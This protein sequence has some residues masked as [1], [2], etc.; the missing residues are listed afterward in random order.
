LDHVLLFQRGDDSKG[1][2]YHIVLSEYDLC[3][4]LK[5]YGKDFIGYDTKHDFMSVRFSTALVSFS[6]GENR[7][8]TGAIGISNTEN[9]ESHCLN[10]QILFAN[11][12][13]SNADCSHPQDLYIFNDLNG[14][15]FIRPCAVNEPICPTVQHDKSISIKSALISM[16]L[17]SALCNFHSLNAFRKYIVESPT[18]K[19]F[20]RPLETCFK[21]V[22]R[23]WNLEIRTKM[24]YFFE[25]F[26][27]FTIPDELLPRSVKHAFLEY[28]QKNWFNCDWSSDFTSEI[29][30]NTDVQER[31]NPLILTD[32]LTERKFRD[33]DDNI[34]NGHLNKSMAQFALVLVDKL[35]AS[36]SKIC[37]NSHGQA[38]NFER[39]GRIR[40]VEDEM[41]RIERGFSLINNK[42]VQ[43]SDLNSS[44]REGWVRISKNKTNDMNKNDQGL[45]DNFYTETYDVEKVDFF[46]EVLEHYGNTST[47]KKSSKE[48]SDLVTADHPYDAVGNCKNII[49]GLEL[50]AARILS[51]AVLDCF[52]IPELVRENYNPDLYYI[53]NTALGICT[54]YSFIIRG[55]PYLC[56]HLYAV[57]SLQENVFEENAMIEKAKRYVPTF[58]SGVPLSQFKPQLNSIERLKSFSHLATDDELENAKKGSLLKLLHDS[59]IPLNLIPGRTANRLPHYGGF[60]RNNPNTKTEISITEH[61]EELFTDPYCPLVKFPENAK[62]RHGGR[63]RNRPTSRGI[64]FSHV[65]YSA[66]KEL[67]IKIKKKGQSFPSISFS[68]E[69]SGD[70]FV[71]TESTSCPENLTKILDE[72]LEKN[73]S[74]LISN[75]K[76]KVNLNKKKSR[77]I[78]ASNIMCSICIERKSKTI[79]TSSSSLELSNHVKKV[80]TKNIMTCGDCFQKSG[81]SV[82]F[83][84]DRKMKEHFNMFHSVTP[85][86]VT[87]TDQIPSN[88]I[89][90]NNFNICK[91]DALTDINVINCAD[92][93]ELQSFIKPPGKS[94]KRNLAASKLQGIRKQR[95]KKPPAPRFDMLL[96]ENSDSK[97]IYYC[98]ICKKV[99]EYVPP[100]VACD[101]C[102]NWY[103]WRCV[104]LKKNPGKKVWY[105]PPCLDLVDLPVVH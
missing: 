11:I 45:P 5:I 70:E 34:N 95:K 92:D 96:P 15:F 93:K 6:D 58:C 88:N 74:A 101:A 20:L 13:C 25:N 57:L 97:K 46:E 48:L 100:T 83:N 43:L 2:S 60:R 51:D 65:L 39:I 85:D 9:K 47:Q 99:C 62:G 91:D 66:L 36:E 73:M 3:K 32:N 49:K 40:S 102:D 16:G 37:K 64:N 1:R 87:A 18:L 105:C 22:M 14:Y 21:C 78:T 41:K 103:H 17:K 38:E 67:C 50:S 61:P 56:K 63:K 4:V 26:V 76:Q 12:P 104:G 53:C 81:I 35:F 80:H 75:K 84:C 90:Q 77:P 98:P 68:P 31:R 72:K 94:G 19:V 71:T 8:R 69:D 24:M 44:Q 42:L 89:D 86:D 29:M 23:S 7:G 55:Q 59:Y 52:C 10:L 82:T 54:C 33:I 30:Y 28:M 27:N 79:F